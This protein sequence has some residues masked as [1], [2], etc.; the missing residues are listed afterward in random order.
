MNNIYKMV[1]TTNEKFKYLEGT[2]GILQYDEAYNIYWFNNFH[3]SSIVKT[4]EWKTKGFITIK[5]LNSVY[6][7]KK[8][9]ETI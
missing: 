7:F 6:V 3:T 8:T 4:V 1:S 2:T 9:K 5:T